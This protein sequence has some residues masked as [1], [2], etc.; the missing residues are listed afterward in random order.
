MRDET[1][2]DIVPEATREKAK[3]IAAIDRTTVH[4]ICSG[5]VVLNLATAVKELLENSIDAGATQVEIRL[6]DHGA[7]LIEVNDNGSGVEE[8]NFQGLTLKHHTSKLRDFQDLVGV[9]TF[10]FR[11]EALSS[12]CALSNVSISTRHKDAALGS[13]VSYDHNGK[14]TKIEKS[15]RSV[16]TTVTLKDIFSTMPVRHKEFGR[17]VKREFNK[18]C[19]VL[20]AYCLVSTGVRIMCSNTLGKGKKN[21]VVATK[22]DDNVKDNIVSVFGT[23]QFGTLKEISNSDLTEEELKDIGMRTQPP[24]VQLTGYVSNCVHGDGR[25]AGDR[26]YFY[27]NSRPCDPTKINKSVNEVY[28]SY[29][30]HQYP[31]IFLNIQTNRTT[32]DV[33][34]TPDKRQVFLQNEKYLCSLIKKSLES[35]FKDAPSSIP[36][37]SFLQKE[38]RVTA[39][40]IENRPDNKQLTLENLKRKFSSERAAESENKPSN[41]QPKLDSYFRRVCPNSSGDTEKTKPEGQ[42]KTCSLELQEAA[43]ELQEAGDRLESQLEDPDQQYDFT[44]KEDLS[45]NIAETENGNEAIVDPEPSSSSQPPASIS[46]EADTFLNT[47]AESPMFKASQTKIVFNDFVQNKEQN[48]SQPVIIFDDFGSNPKPS[49][50]Q[51]SVL[52]F[53]DFKPK[54]SENSSNSHILSSQP[55]VI[56]DD[57]NPSQR[58]S[59]SQSVLIFDD[60]ATTKNKE[61]NIEDSGNSSGLKITFDDFSQ[62]DKKPAIVELEPTAVNVANVKISMVDDTS[63]R[64][65]RKENTFKFSMDKLRKSLG[66][67]SLNRANAD[68]SL[69]FSAKI[70]PDDNKTAEKELQRQISKADFSEMSIFGQ[71]NLGFIIVGLRDDLFIVDQHA[72]DEKY[73]FETLQRNTVINSQKMVAPQSLELTAANENLLIDNM[74]V[75]E[76]NGFKFSIEESAPPTQRVKLTSLPI[77]KNW[78]FGKEDIDELLFLLSECVEGTVTRPSRVRAMFAS[79]ACR[80]SVMIGKHLSPGDMRRLV[81]HMGEIEQPWNCPHGRPTI[82]HLVNTNM[83]G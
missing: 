43:L 15:A 59:A 38:R 74:N 42:E 65:A 54:G 5:Q 29:N 55:V 78:T 50:S 37:N 51:S 7:S 68:S 4:Q 16:G 9:E 60:F 18:L 49:S 76:K 8:E 66:D 32:V 13:T 47:K 12:L 44:E 39:E 17:N 63:T 27:I 69:K 33:N 36:I 6:K 21:V 57:F 62:S 64:S 10:G 3:S 14:I 79:R 2:E 22:G 26:Q 82:R 71:F 61:N 77:S 19:Q 34:I 75:F 11:G 20:N 83:L 46:P 80:S 52:I 67:C 45:D 81:D 35:I 23:K 58:K 28:H 40:D 70:S 72:T 41:K 24:P 56:F 53:D 1:G 31:F 25:G 73:N 30:R 48:S